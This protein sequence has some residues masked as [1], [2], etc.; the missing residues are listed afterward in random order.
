MVKLGAV[1]VLALAACR[2][3][4][5]HGA[6]APPS[7]TPQ[8]SE[9]APLAE[10]QCLP[11]MICDEWAG[12][13]LVAKDP[14]GRWSVVVADRLP[15]GELVRVENGCTTGAMCLT[16]KAVPRGVTC[17]PHTIPPLISPPGYTCV[18][19]ASSCRKS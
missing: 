13:A 7:G 10:H 4:G 19:D 6:P 17:A 5:P 1:M 18:R 9:A 16:A 15:K 8:S 2:G 12:C 3:D 11:A 14:Q